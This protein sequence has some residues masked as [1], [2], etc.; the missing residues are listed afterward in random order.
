[1]TARSLPEWV[2]ATPDSPI[3]PRVRVRVA[4]RAGRCCQQCTRPILEGDRGEVDH[5]VALVN[6][7]E[8]RESNLRFI[9]RWCHA[10]KTLADV[11]EKSR[12]S[13]RLKRSLGIKTRSGRP[14][15]GSRAS[16]IRKRMSG[17]VERW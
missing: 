3:P 6:G 10:K 5:I 9:C 17:D 16:G 4:M 1:V 11:E 15:P 12:V 13:R 7:G 8:N 2:G 14:I